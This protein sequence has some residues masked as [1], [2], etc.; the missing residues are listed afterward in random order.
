MIINVSDLLSI[1]SFAGV[2]PLFNIS[3]SIFFLFSPVSQSKTIV[4]QYWIK[5]K[6]ADVDIEK[7]IFLWDQTS[8]EDS[9][10]C[11]MNQKGIESQAYQPGKYGDLEISLVHYQK[12]YLDHLQNYIKGLA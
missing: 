1:K 12:F 6:E 8:K 9:Q 11:E 5:H 2:F 7:M 4:T 10:L 3:E